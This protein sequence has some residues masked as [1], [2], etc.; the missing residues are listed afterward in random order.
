MGSIIVSP[1]NKQGGYLPLGRRVSVIGR[2][3][4]VA[5]QILDE[6]VSRRHLQV[7]FDEKTGGYIAID[8]NSANGTFINGK[9]LTGETPL[10]DGDEL[11]VGNTKLLFSDSDFQDRDSA[12]AHFKKVGERRRSTLIQ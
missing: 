6:R 7:R 4:A 2:D 8:L 9:R 3:E 11:L 10:T 12:L 1:E 5:L